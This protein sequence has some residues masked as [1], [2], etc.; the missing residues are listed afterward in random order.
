MTESILL[1][2]DLGTTALAG[3]LATSSGQV[4]AEAQTDNPQCRFGDDVIRRLEAAQEGH[5]GELQLLLAD[6]INRLVAE[7]STQAGIAVTD[8]HAAAAAANPAVTHLLASQPVDRILFPPHRP[9]FTGGCGLDSR[10][11]NIDLPVPIY[12]LPIRSGYVGGDL[13][14]VLLAGDPPTGPTIYIDLGTNAEL[15][16]W[17][18]Q[19]WLVTSVA[20][21]PAFE[22][23]HL[24][25]GMRHG[26][27]AVRRVHCR[28]ER[29][30]LEVA[31]DFVPRG[32]CGSGFF[33][34]VTAALEGGLIDAHGRIRTADEVDTLLS[35]YLVE[36]EAGSALQLYRDARCRLLI[37]QEDVR[38]FQ[39]AKG[40]V[41]SGVECLLQRASLEVDDVVTVN[42]AG[43]L[44][45]ALSPQDL[46]GVAM[47]PENMLDKVRFLPS[48]VL[49]GVMILLADEEGK[50]RARQLAA[51]LKPYPLSGTPAFERSFLRSLDFS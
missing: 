40:A 49:D 35:R 28:L 5:G 22:A 45:A 43:A 18:G 24:S 36:T 48:A 7:L 47:I 14:A 23:G 17:D 29:L 21:G 11:L 2:L 12:V 8:I 16:L 32:V 50:E 37:T 41:F 3:R 46:K 39:T 25:C 10:S 27:G 9:D 44:G 33:S 51:A 31:E 6:G 34:A 38:A 4:L 19:S 26:P 42:I 30:E 13:L 15:A 1:A 20:A